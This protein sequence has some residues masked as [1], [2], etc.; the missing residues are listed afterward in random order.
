MNSKD[1]K[2]IEGIPLRSHSSSKGSSQALP[3][4][5]SKG[6]ITL[7]TIIL[8]LLTISASGSLLSSPIHPIA[9]VLSI[10]IPAYLFLIFAL[11]RKH[12][13]F[14]DL[15]IF[16]QKQAIKLQIFTQKI[17]SKNDSSAFQADPALLLRLTKVIMHYAWSIIFA[18]LII[19][20]FFQFTLKQYHFNLFS[21]LFPDES[22]FYFTI[23]YVMNWLPELIFGEIISA[24]LIVSSL[25]KT[26]TDSENAIWARWII[27]M[28]LIYGLLPRLI[29]LFFAR[30]SYQQYKKDH[31]EAETI[32][33]GIEK[34]IDPAKAQPKHE[35]LPKVI[36]NG[37]GS[38]AI[39]LDYAGDL[40]PEITIINDRNRFNQLHLQLKKA[41]LRSLTIYIDSSLTPD[42]SLLRRIYTLMNLSLSNEIILIDKAHHSRVKEWQEKLSPHLLENEKISVQSHN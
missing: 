32:I 5:L 42:R 28:I 37:E 11:I 22:G 35:R 41:P 12:S 2:E 20:L 33:Q 26:L 31:P 15:L 1:N 24:E 38:H 16:L 21:T 25:N 3:F 36:T 10:L 9:L 17:T 6:I 34:L 29:L 4:N 23:I 14:A 19:S 13:L 30:R 7:F 39:A 18:A 40:T 8:A 27:I